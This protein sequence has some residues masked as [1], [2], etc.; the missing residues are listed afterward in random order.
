MTRSRRRRTRR[1]GLTAALTA[2]LTAVPALW[3]AAPAAQADPA[4]HTPAAHRSAD[5]GPAVRHDTSPTLRSM[6]AHAHHGHHG[7][8]VQDDDPGEQRLPHPPASPLPDPVVQSSPGGPSAPSTG[9]NFEGIGAG[10]YSITGVPPDPNAAVGAGQIVETVNTAYAV[11]SKSGATVLAPTDTSTLWSGFGGSCQTTNDGDAVVRWDT[12]ASRWVVTQFANVSSASGPYYECVAV[13]TGT[14]ATGS[15]YRYSFQYADFPDYP[16]LSVWPDAYYVT[17][18]MFTASGSFL[19]AEACALNRSAMLTGAAAGQ[20]CFTTSSSYGG[21]LGADLDGST[22][23]P[24]GEPELMTG[25]GTTST[26][27]A[28]WKFHTDWTT[29]ANSS[30][31]GPT[32]LTVASY[33]TACGSSGT[34]IPQSGTSQQL[35]S[36]SDRLMFR[37]AYRN[38]G[39]HESLVVNHAVTAGSSVGVRWYELRMSGG[40]PTV[41]QQG[42]YAP[43]STYRWMGSIAEDKAGNIALGYSQ[44]S[45]SA[46]PSSR[47]TGRLAGDTLGTMTQ[48]EVTAITGGGSQ[49]SY[50]RWGDYTSMAVD[51]TDDCTFWYTN[52]YI[53]ANGNFNWHTRLASFTLPN[54]GSTA[55]NDFSV[56]VSPASASVA[57][58]SPATTTVSTAVTSGSAQSVS[59]SA[60]GLPSGA[61]A[62]FTPSTVTAGGSSTL[63]V[64]TS[65]STPAGTYNITVTGTG[66]SATHTAT[67]TLTVTSG[68]GGGITNGGFETGSLTGWTSTG[69]TSVVNSGAHSGTYA[70]RVGGT[71]PTN[72][73]SSIAQTFTAPSGTSTLGFFYNVTCPDTLTYDWATATLKDNTTG[74]TTTVLAKTCVSSS[75]WIQK[76]ASVTAGHSY[77][78]TLI[79]HDD[80][81]SGDAT[82]TRYDDVTLS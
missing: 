22:A 63:T 9:T 20:Q 44:S 55:S 78:L 79:S 34:C 61:T 32:S 53:P 80:N 57:A 81:Y 76:T 51:P 42:T 16:K 64:G 73:D 12:L 18:N 10:N 46:H 62:S 41:Y 21:L 50:S 2:I 25:L 68:G 19:D 43:D 39:D 7:K 75:G 38:F 71:S 82:Y 35:D 60:S 72:G 17:Y 8:K 4:P 70:A 45:S 37:L 13:S 48:G 58:G 3:F 69:T 54:C 47:Y 49:T 14:D 27:L 26:T 59:L 28:Y 23:P 56:S 29:P 11:Y 36:L 52:E 40:N 65:S 66:A 5:T 31:S 24:S 1:R 6:A 74:T 15:Y 33:T 77:T 30:F 67:F